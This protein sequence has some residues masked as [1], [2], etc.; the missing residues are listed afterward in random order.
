MEKYFLAFSLS[1]GVG[2][3]RFQNLLKIF[4]S[5]ESAW[6]GTAKQYSNA[7]VGKSA[8]GKFEEF[9]KV[10]DIGAYLE[11][12]KKAK[13][14]FIPFGDKLYPAA[15]QKLPSPPVGLFVRGNKKLVAEKNQVGVVGARKIT[16]YGREVTENIVAELVR[17]N[18]VI[19]SGMALGVDGVAHATAVENKGSTIAVLGCGVDCPYPRENERL[20]EQILDSNGLIISEYPLGMPA[21]QGTF[22][23]RNRIIAALSCAVLIT[24]AAEDS[25]SLITASNAA[26]LGK[27]VFAVPGPITSQMSRGSIKLIKDGAIL[28]SSAED[29]LDTLNIKKQISPPKADG[30]LAQNISKEEKKIL[31]AIENE[32]RTIDEIAKITKIPISQISILISGL[33]MNG[34]VKLNSGQIVLSG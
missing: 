2:P 20:Y 3:K 4:G 34:I 31:N 15:L 9:R 10:F 16:S 8:F 6:E 17:N 28:V 18:I 12:L 22:P 29:I 23:A 19:T 33:E 5:A 32:A 14:E 27:K 11:R 24:E 21:N 7:G 25:G 13:V 26:S 30:P 1:P